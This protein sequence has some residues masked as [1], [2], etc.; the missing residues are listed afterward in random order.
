MDQILCVV[1]APVCLDHTGGIHRM[2]AIPSGGHC[3]FHGPL[4]EGKAS[5]SLLRVKVVEAGP[6]P[7]LTMVEQSKVLSHPHPTWE[8]SQT[9][10][11]L[12]AGMGA[13]G[14]GAAKRRISSQS[15][16]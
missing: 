12:C 15:R 9:V 16:V 14:N 1:V 6:I 11:E 3:R 10:I 8:S 4:E 7:L 13:L 2:A 5:Y